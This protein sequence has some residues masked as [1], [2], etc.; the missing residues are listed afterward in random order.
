MV[1]SVFVLEDLSL[2]PNTYLCIHT[3][4]VDTHTDTYE[5]K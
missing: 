1:M 2:F 4:M 5:H 3:Q